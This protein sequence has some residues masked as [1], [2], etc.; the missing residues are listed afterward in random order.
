MSDPG[1]LSF[2]TGQLAG[3]LSR[4]AFA[5]ALVHSDEYDRL[6]IALAY[7]KYLGRAP[8][9]AASDFW[10]AQMRQGLTD[11]GLQADLIGSAEYYARAGGTD[12]S[13]IDRMYS[14]LLGRPADA[15]GE[16]YW[17][18]KIQTGV[19]R[20]AIAVSIGN[21]AEAGQQTIVSDYT[22]YLGRSPASSDINYWLNQFAA[23]ATNED[24]IAGFVASDEYFA[25]AGGI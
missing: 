5:S 15:A 3:G 6:V 19:S 22:R 4:L 23:G 1:S 9:P 17:N 24:V 25:R 8:D 12:T 16:A 7:S 10:T 2:W 14:D 13:W 11:Q 20:D 18:G 21:G